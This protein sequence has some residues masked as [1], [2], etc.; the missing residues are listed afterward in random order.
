MRPRVFIG[1]ASSDDRMATTYALALRLQKD[2][3]VVSR[4]WTYAF[5]PTESTLSSLVAISQ[6]MDFAVF[7]FGPDDLVVKQATSNPEGK[8][9]VVEG[10]KWTTRDN[11][12]FEMGLLI[13][14]LGKERC[15]AVLPDGPRSVGSEDQRR[16]HLFTDYLGINYCT[17]I[18]SKEPGLDPLDTVFAA[19]QEIGGQIRK[20]GP[21]AINAFR[22]LFGRGREAIVVYP[23]ITANT[24]GLVT[25]VHRGRLED[26]VDHEW[27]KVDLERQ[28]VALLDDLRA[29][30]AIAELCGG[31]GV[32]VTGST[33]GMEQPQI[34]S[35]DSMSFSIGL[36]NGFTIQAIDI[37]AAD[38]GGLIRLEHTN[39]EVKPEPGSMI[40]FNG[41]TYPHP[42]EPDGSAAQRS[43]EGQAS[44]GSQSSR[45]SPAAGPATQDPAAYNA[46]FAIVV[47]MFLRSGENPIPR[48]VCG[49]CQAPGTAVAGV[50]LKNHWRDLLNYYEFFAKDLEQDNLAVL[51]QFW[52]RKPESAR[53]EVIRLAFFSASHTEFHRYNRKEKRWER[54][55]NASTN[56]E[57]AVKAPE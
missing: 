29:V 48:F 1:S 32:E 30:N 21:R 16:L 31:M 47:R 26:K 18:A 50:Y 46:D 36:L 42:L 38:S 35:L 57:A 28:E 3:K 8:G 12:I 19:C 56:V 34:Q 40:H 24:G 15:F 41:E 10:K 20:H 2:F 45:S 7:V 43:Q 53:P 49:G 51:L 25:I 44:S 6:E 22:A 5:P 14:A 4:V 13:G 23:H 37:I 52:G 55:D 27:K 33:D 9:V 54:E 39:Y 11:V 17:Y